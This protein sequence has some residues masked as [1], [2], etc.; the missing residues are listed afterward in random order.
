MSVHFSQA[1]D[2][3]GTLPLLEQITLSEFVSQLIPQSDQDRD[4]LQQHSA[5]ECEAE[6][7][8]HDL[9][10][11]PDA[12]EEHTSKLD[13][14][15]LS[16]AAATSSLSRGNSQELPA[17]RPGHQATVSV[18]SSL[19]GSFKEG[20]YSVS[21]DETEY[22]GSVSLVSRRGLT[23]RLD[24]HS[25]H[26]SRDR[27]TECRRL[28]HDSPSRSPSRE[29]KR[30]SGLLPPFLPSRGREQE[31]HFEASPSLHGDCSMS[32]GRRSIRYDSASPPRR[33]R[34]TLRYDSASPPRRSRDA[35]H[36]ESASPQRRRRDTSRYVSVSPSRRSRD[37]S[38]YESASPP[39]RKADMRRHDSTSPYRSGSSV[40]RRNSASRS[41]SRADIY[42]DTYHDRREATPSQPR[43]NAYDVH[44]HTR[45]TWS[46][47]E[48]SSSESDYEFH[49]PR[50]WGPR[51]GPRFKHLDSIAKDIEQFDPEK[52]DHNVRII[53][54]SLSAA[55]QTYPTPQGRSGLS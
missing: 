9:K 12:L 49:K 2:M 38:R 10:R 7:L 4:E 19:H 33:S 42:R 47:G 40:T 43:R 37:A 53:S 32:C 46:E 45:T 21:E 3:E 31:V 14:S 26:G 20:E 17:S 24:A 13:E 29:E 36:N 1:S 18:T 48:S 27:S 39:R 5:E 11:A 8:R 35:S 6:D 25:R 34:D 50:S 15:E 41:R 16:Q 44:A 54:M 52:Q 23:R 30:R 55:S 28:T 22:Y 51:H